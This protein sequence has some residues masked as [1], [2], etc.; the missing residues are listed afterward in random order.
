MDPLPYFLVMLSKD[1][2]IIMMKDSIFQH[3]T[4]ETP[5]ELDDE[6]DNKNGTANAAA[7]TALKISSTA[8]DIEDPIFCT[9]AVTGNQPD[10]QSIFVCNDCFQI[11]VGER[12]REEVAIADGEEEEEQL[13]LLSL[14]HYNTTLCICQAC[15]D[16]CHEGNFHDTVYVGMGPATCDCNLSG[17]CQLYERSLMEAM[18]LGIP[19]Q[20]QL[21]QNQHVDDQED[22][23]NNN[24]DMATSTTEITPLPDLMKIKMFNIPQLK[25]ATIAS[26]LVDQANELIRHTK[27]TH[28]VDKSHITTATNL[29]DLEL[30][31]WNIYQYHLVMYQDILDD[32]RD[33]GAEWWV[34][35]KALDEASSPTNNCGI[36]LHYDKDEALAESFGL[37]SFPTL[38]TVTYLTSGLSNSP[39]TIVLD[40][41]YPQEEEE[42]MSQ[43]LLSRPRR[44][45]HL[46]FDGRLLHGAPYHPK[47]QHPWKEKNQE[48]NH[49]RVTVLVNIWKD[50]RPANVQ[51]LDNNIRQ[52][53]VSLQ[54]DSK[55]LFSIPLS[56]QT[57][58]IPTIQLDKEDQLPE[59]LQERIELPFVSDKGALG[60]NNVE[61]QCGMMVVTFPPPPFEDSV[62]V[63]FGPGMQAYLEYVQE[64]AKEETAHLSISEELEFDLPSK[65]SD[66]V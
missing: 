19:L 56:M 48:T 50:R 15:A 21:R 57:L 40:H 41:T 64:E 14:H 60:T 59:Q 9:F 30:L 47:L 33:G 16:V 22:G 43:L 44:G 12:D 23:K 42:V 6:A 34:Q 62:L 54:P 18:R 46:V 8:D 28:W 52:S 39:P 51:I 4:N 29:S 20:P 11:D 65:Q 24:Y 32:C 2:N 7:A 27:E 31:A 66:Y 37:G 49:W 63:L 26:R 53:L 17:K 1:S 61:G 10:F 38:S 58:S 45:K 3:H 13:L 25:D 5:V 35:V 36:D 55:P